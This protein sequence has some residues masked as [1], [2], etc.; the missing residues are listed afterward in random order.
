MERLCFEL[1]RFLEH[2]LN[3]YDGRL[4]NWAGDGGLLAFTFDGHV[5][6][7][8]MCAVDIQSSLPLFNISPTTPI[9]E[10]VELRLGVDTGTVTFLSDT[11]RIISDVINYAA[12]LEK[13]AT[14]AGYVSLSQRVC[15]QCSPRILSIFEDAGDF[16]GRPYRTTVQRLDALFDCV[17][18][19]AEVAVG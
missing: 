11:G 10:R 19:C 7:A 6:R 3:D 9:T 4:W 8:V 12:H 2:K 13:N 1:W 5:D 18:G 17:P 16:E 15:F 14:Q